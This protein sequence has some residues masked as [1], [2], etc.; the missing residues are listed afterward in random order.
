MDLTEWHERHQLVHYTKSPEVVAS[1]LENGFLLVPNRRE[2]IERFLGSEDFKGREPQEFGMVSFT[3]LQKERAR[4]H[5]EIFGDF[6]VVVTWEWAVHHR[7]Q[8]VLYVGDGPVFRAFKWLFEFGKQEILRHDP[9]A[10]KGMSLTN[11]AVAMMY[12]QMYGHLLTIYEY[13]QPERDSSQVEWR[14]ANPIPHY[15]NR[16]SDRD[17]M[18]RELVRLAKSK[19]C[20]LQVEPGHV[21]MLLCPAGDAR[22]LKAAIPA[23]FRGVPIIPYSKLG[24]LRERVRAGLG[25]ISSRA[26]PRWRTV[27]REAPPPADCVVLRKNASVAG[28]YALPQVER[29]N[30]LVVY[31][32]DVLGRA[33]GNLQY[34]GVD[35]SEFEVRL[36]F[37]D[38]AR[39]WAYLAD[40]AAEPRFKG[41]FDLAFRRLCEL[42]EV[43][44]RTE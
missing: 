4:H 44:A 5:R 38:I 22:R 11:R 1:I 2:L 27:Y 43:R 19:M 3:E 20:T 16:Y 39:L 24:T 28:I 17:L 10:S 6:G 21:E 35:G 15:H 36:P 34:R 40:M 13:M 7:A 42:G 30:G 25:A 8:R 26:F 32:D 41:L 31:G 12:N 33:Y 37:I 14:I 23:A 29:V 18:M 9:E